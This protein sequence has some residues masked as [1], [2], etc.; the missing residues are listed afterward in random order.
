MLYQIYGLICKMVELVVEFSKEI[1]SDDYGVFQVNLGEDNLDEKVK[2][3]LIL[4]KVS[5]L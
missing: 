3:W 2:E 5:V 4:D 1:D